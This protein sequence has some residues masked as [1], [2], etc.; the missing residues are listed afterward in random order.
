ML[1]Q[2]NTR[3]PRSPLAVIRNNIKTSLN[4]SLSR[5]ISPSFS[6][7]SRTN[8]NYSLY[9]PARSHSKSENVKPATIKGKHEQLIKQ[10]KELGR[11]TKILEQKIKEI[12]R[13]VQNEVNITKKK[14]IV[15]DR[16]VG[17]VEKKIGDWIGKLVKRNLRW[18]FENLK[19]V[20]PR[21][22]N[23]NEKNK[24]VWKKNLLKKVF[25]SLRKLAIDE[26]DIEK[27]KVQ[28]ASRHYK[29]QL[30]VT[31]FMKWQECIMFKDKGNI[32]H[33]DEIELLIESF[34]NDSMSQT[35]ANF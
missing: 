2:R 28:I 24:M 3:N 34:I 1:Y 15:K 16:K 18:V 21:D 4:N 32:T 10:R 23:V 17:E 29:L 13:K 30:M 31:N 19:G 9:I 6:P 22:L 11:E 7:V 20:K 8:K 5:S 35:F 14:R 12:R 27:E 26:K 33:N 25:F